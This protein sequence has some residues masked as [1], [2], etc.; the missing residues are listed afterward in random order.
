[1]AYTFIK[2][3]GGKVGK[4]LVEDDYIET[5]IEILKIAKEL[6]A[7]NAETSSPEFFGVLGILCG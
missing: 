4:S 6:T 1:M 2:A 7:E 5:A 3:Q